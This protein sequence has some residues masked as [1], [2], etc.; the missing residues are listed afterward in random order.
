MGRRRRWWWGWICGGGLRRQGRQD[1]FSGDAHG[2]EALVPV[3]TNTDSWITPATRTA[4][5]FGG[6]ASAEGKPE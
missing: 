5:K 1:D 4:G 6:A 3:V 2:V